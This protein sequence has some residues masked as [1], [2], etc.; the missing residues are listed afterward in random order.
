ML[1]WSM[2]CVVH[3]SACRRE[4]HRGYKRS[5]DESSELKGIYRK[6]MHIEKKRVER[7]VLPVSL[8]TPFRSILCGNMLLRLIRLREK[9]LRDE[10]LSLGVDV[11]PHSHSLEPALQNIVA[12]RRA[13]HERLMSAI[14]ILDGTVE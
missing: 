8:H 4:G 13:F 1:L 10:E 5:L 11:D 2:V 7:C 6:A 9:H 3:G 12:M 14:D